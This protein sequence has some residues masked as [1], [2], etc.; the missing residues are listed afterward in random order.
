[1]SSFIINSSNL[2]LESPELA[3]DGQWGMLHSYMTNP[4]PLDIEQDVKLVLPLLANLHLG[5]VSR[6]R[7]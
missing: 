2:A 3:L 5:Y 7:S 4:Q 6:R 1:M